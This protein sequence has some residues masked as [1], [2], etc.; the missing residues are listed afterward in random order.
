MRRGLDDGH[1]AFM[2]ALEEFRFAGLRG[3]HLEI[4]TLFCGGPVSDDLFCAW[5]LPCG[6]RKLQPV[7]DYFSWGA[8]LGSTVDTRSGHWLTSI[9]LRDLHRRDVFVDI[10]IPSSSTPF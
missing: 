10:H 8:M 3:L 7:G 4:C 9:S 1:L 6:V 5:V 2:E